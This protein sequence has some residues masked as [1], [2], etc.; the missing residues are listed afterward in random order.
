MKKFFICFIVCFAAVLALNFSAYAISGDGTDE[1]PFLIGSDAD[2]LVIKSFPDKYY[3][4]I[5]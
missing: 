5:N 3:K 2:I 1:N 4:L